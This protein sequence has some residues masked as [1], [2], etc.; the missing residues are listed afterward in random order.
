MENKKTKIH[1]YTQ[2]P[3]ASGLRSR[4]KRWKKPSSKLYNKI[5][6]QLIDHQTIPATVVV[7][8]PKF[9]IDKPRCHPP[10]ES[11]FPVRFSGS[12][13]CFC[14]AWLVYRRALG[15]PSARMY[16]LPSC[17][18]RCP[19]VWRAGWV[20]KHYHSKPLSRSTR[21]NHKRLYTAHGHIHNLALVFVTGSSKQAR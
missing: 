6:R 18:C 17:L 4:H 12:E 10:K 5:V 1:K 16:S 20:A 14:L 8:S 13:E 9:S 3:T 2:N 19:V 7:V 15:L 11:R 21:V